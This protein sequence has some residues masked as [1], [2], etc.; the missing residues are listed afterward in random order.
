MTHTSPRQEANRLRQI[1]ILSPVLVALVVLVSVRALS[2]GPRGASAAPTPPDPAIAIPT[3]HLAMG[4]PTHC[5]P[6]R[7]R[8]VSFL[9]DTPLETIH[10]QCNQVHGY[11][12]LDDAGLPRVGAWQLPVV[13]LRTGLTSRDEHLTRA[14]WLDAAAYPF[15]RFDLARVEDPQPVEDPSAP[16]TGARTIRCTL[17]GTLTLRGVSRPLVVPGAMV[18]TLPADTAPNAP[19]RG[20]LVAL[21]GAFDVA[22]GDF[23]IEHAMITQRGKVAPVLR[24]DLTLV[25]STVPP[26]DQPGGPALATRSREP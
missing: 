20:S 15:V 24:M 8:Q 5:L 3:E 11:M 23:G 16:R 1:A 21:R 2:P 7:D 13:S 6:G 18:T 10:G 12:V 19:V 9:S 17:V 26:E 25:H 22:L 14:E 4:T